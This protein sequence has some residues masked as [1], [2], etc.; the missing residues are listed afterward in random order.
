MGDCGKANVTN[1]KNMKLVVSAIW[2]SLK[3][4]L[5]Y[6]LFFAL[7][8]EIRNNL[9]IIHRRTEHQIEIQKKVYYTLDLSLRAFMNHKLQ[10]M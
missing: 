6:F 5:G 4:I 2:K 10:F 7:Q 3:E 8:S 9:V 1:T